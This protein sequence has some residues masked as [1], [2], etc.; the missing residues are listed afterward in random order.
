MSAD[1]SSLILMVAALAMGLFRYVRA[2]RE[3]HANENEPGN[4]CR[5]GPEARAENTHG[6]RIVNVRLSSE[7][8]A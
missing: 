3:A 4:M 7:A 2:T 6:A 5:P 8:D 1:D